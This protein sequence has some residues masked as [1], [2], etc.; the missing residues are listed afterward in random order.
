M[1]RNKEWQR[2]YKDSV[3]GDMGPKA[4]FKSKEV[5]EEARTCDWRPNLHDSCEIQRVSTIYDVILP[6]KGDAGK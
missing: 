5:A 1:P 3:F 4:V 6:V 2:Q